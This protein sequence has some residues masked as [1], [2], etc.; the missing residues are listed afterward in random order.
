[1][2]WDLFMQAG[3]Q[4]Q[5]FRLCQYF[6]SQFVRPKLF[7]GNYFAR[8]AEEVGIHTEHT[9]PCLVLFTELE[10]SVEEVTSWFLN[11][12]IRRHV[13]RLYWMDS[14]GQFQETSSSSSKI[15]A[16]VM[17]LTENSPGSIAVSRQELLQ[18]ISTL[19]LE[20]TTIFR[21]SCNPRSLEKF[22]E[23]SQE[24][25]SLTLVHALLYH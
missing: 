21:L 20:E 3:H 4:S 10:L 2:P 13:T 7:P 5:A 14:R 19:S 12:L 16:R 18:Q 25:L 11:S 22:L 15:D 17:Q 24:Y 8:S 23:V 1:M 9:G 6:K